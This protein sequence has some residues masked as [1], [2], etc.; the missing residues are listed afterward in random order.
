VINF[1]SLRAKRTS[2][3]L[4]LEEADPDIIV[5][6]E[7]WL[8][9]G[10]SE[11][12]VLPAGY[13][14]VSRKDRIQDRHGGV[15][16]AAK[17]SITGTDIKLDTYAE[18]T[19]SSLVCRGKDP[20]IIVAIYRP[21][22]SDQTY[23]EEVCRQMRHLH[24][25]YPTSTIWLAGDINLPDIDWTTCSI[26]G[27]NYPHRIS[28]LFLDMVHDTSSEQVVNFPTRGANTLDLFVTNRPSL[29]E[30]CKVLPGV[31]DH[32]IVLVQAQTSATRTKPPR[33]KILLWKDVDTD[34]MNTAVQNFST[35][36]IARHTTSTNISTLWQTFR[37]FVD[38]TI[39]SHVPSKM[40]ST[41]F[42][43][44]WITRKAKRLS[45]RKKRAYIRARTTHSEADTKLFED[46]KKDMRHECRRAHNSYVRNMVTTDRNPKKLYSFIKGKRCDSSG[47]SPL[48][49]NGV[50]HADAATKAAILNNQFSSVFTVEDKTTIPS[51]GDSPHPD[52]H[53]FDIGEEGVRKL[54]ANLDPHKATGPD[55][56]PSRFLKDHAAEL[57]AP[58]AL[59]FQASLQQGEVS[60]DWRHANVTP[61]FKKG[62]HSDPANYRPISLAHL[63]LQQAHGTHLALPDHVPPRE[64]PY[65]CRRAARVPEEEIHR[66][67]ADTY[68]AGPS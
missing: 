65:S 66:E 23:M 39:Q 35:D 5:G 22:S 13:H 6:S 26:K 33:R 25:A 51:P 63:C 30:R 67:P 45:R 21:P 15:A 48:K 49:S 10:I 17:D 3:W 29:V 60:S 46:A 47:V 61:V 28:Q 56:I 42:S 32:D 36:F 62:D 50:T 57:A 58:L 19:A 9:P 16:V 55:N 68:L 40:S 59:I 1:Q 12:E 43:Q 54:L 4:L 14:F 24:L 2:F 64:T 37:D 8:Y 20:L 41:R 38:C 11:R 34:T 18:I 44:P 27:N 31:S 7:T 52:I 53:H